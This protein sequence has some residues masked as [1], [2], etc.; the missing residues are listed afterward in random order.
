MDFYPVPPGVEPADVMAAMRQIVSWPF[1]LLARLPARRR[2]VP[3]KGTDGQNRGQ[4]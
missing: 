2:R 4:G 3:A 1:R